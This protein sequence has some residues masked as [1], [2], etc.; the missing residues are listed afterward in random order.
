[1]NMTRKNPLAESQRLG[2][3]QISVGRKWNERGGFIAI[4]WYQS[5]L[6]AMILRG[7]QQLTL[8]HVRTPVKRFNVSADLFLRWP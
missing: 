7:E 1:M 5:H 4:F 2:R 6:G 8:A 3:A